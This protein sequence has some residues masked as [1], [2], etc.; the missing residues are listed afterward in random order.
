LG[1]LMGELGVYNGL[2]N[3]YNSIGIINQ[4]NLLPWFDD[5]HAVL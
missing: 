1:Q 2:K 3:H 4:F 5:Y